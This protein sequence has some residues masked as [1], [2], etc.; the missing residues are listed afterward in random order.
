MLPRGAANGSSPRSRGTSP[1]GTW[2]Y[3]ERRFIPALAGNM[4]AGYGSPT[5]VPVHPRARGEH[6]HVLYATIEEDGSSPRSRGTFPGFAKPQ[7]EHRF[8][9]ALAGNIRR[10]HYPV[11]YP[12]VHPRARG[13]HV[14]LI[15]LPFFLDGSSP[16]SRGTSA[17]LARYGRN[18]RFIPALAGNIE[19]WARSSGFGPVHPR[20][21]G[22]HGSAICPLPIL[23]GSSPRS[24]GTSVRTVSGLPTGT[25]HPRARGE[26]FD[27]QE[28]VAINIGSSPRS[29]GTCA[30][31]GC[32]RPH[33]RFIPAL[34]GNIARGT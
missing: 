19:A 14:F 24:R 6:R 1:G 21:R 7:T 23:C 32:P 27:C 4:G 16:R 28:G 15:F 22:E 30:R 10:T 2:A 5:A 17:R 26:H 20:A 13:E 29:R 34:A 33:D 3:T 8:I 18:G 25:V 31:A 9:P 12:P 11:L